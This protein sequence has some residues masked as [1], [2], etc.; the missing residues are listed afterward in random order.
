MNPYTYIAILVLTGYLDYDVA[1][2]VADKLVHQQFPVS[3]E[4][5]IA[6]I[7]KTVDEVKADR[8]MTR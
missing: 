8:R 5:A 2:A 1:E 6:Q 3:V 4:G 7:N